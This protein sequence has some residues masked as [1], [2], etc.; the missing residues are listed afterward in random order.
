MTDPEF[1]KAFGDY[2]YYIYYAAI[3]L[4]LSII[5][6][7]GIVFFILHVVYLIKSLYPLKLINL[8][9]N[10]FNLVK[11]RTNFILYL[12]LSFVP[13]I[14]ILVLIVAIIIFFILIFFLFFYLIIGFFII[15]IL[16]F[17]AGIFEII[18]WDRLNL[19]F[20]Q[21]GQYFPPYLS[22]QSIQGTKNL[23]LAAICFILGFL[24]ITIFIGVILMFI[25]F[26]QLAKLRYLNE[27]DTTKYPQFIPQ[28]QKAFYP[29]APPIIQPKRTN[30]CP[31][32]GAKLTPPGRFCKECGNKIE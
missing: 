12:V 3:F 16:L 21:H 30:F 13:L 4:I 17:L 9:M 5:P 7:A 10:D 6:F 24:I 27:P 19:F 8:K 11:F 26:F 22:Q 1:N 15:S 25:G 29:P 28:A 23:K 20:Q 32:C 14:G 18:A 2:G 31:F